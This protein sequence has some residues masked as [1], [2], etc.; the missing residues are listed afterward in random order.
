[1]TERPE[2]ATA[3]ASRAASPA[4]R[5]EVPTT[6]PESATTATTAPAPETT[7][8]AG[9]SRLT[10]TLGLRPWFMLALGL[11]AQVAGTVAVTTPAFLVTLLHDQR[12]LSLAQAGLVVAAPSLGMVLTLIAWGALADR[13]GEHWV[14]AAGL[15]ITA[16]AALGALLA[17]DLTAIT[18]FFVIGGMGAASANAAGGRLVVG[19]FPR[20][21]RGLAM[22]IRQ[23]AQPLGV[24]VAAIVVPPIAA[25]NGLNAALLLPFAVTAAA[26]V[27][28]AIF[29]RDPKRAPHDMLPVGQK[30]LNPYRTTSLLWRIHGV[31]VLLVFPQFVVSTF[32]LVWLI[33]DEGWQPLAAGIVVGVAQFVGALGRIVVGLVSDRVGSR[34]LPLRVV[35][36]AAALMMIVLALTDWWG[37]SGLAAVGV[38]LASAITVADNGL[39]FTAVAEIA[40]SRW[41]GRALGAQNTAQFVAAAATAPVMGALIGAFGFAASFGLTAL[42]PLVAI[43]LVPLIDKRSGK[44]L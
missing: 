31:S 16:L 43:P 38:I 7:V 32:A 44:K 36:G 21:R 8:A 13:V 35:A 30:P 27:L 12:G 4:A 3:A 40:G 15:T 11:F 17:G 2:T 39:A 20:E 22:G 34:M 14:I 42:L 23:M 28:S 18:I 29:I 37:F 10:A 41:S 33:T 5:V 26:A 6:A 25:A 24:A 1:M 9:A 19:W